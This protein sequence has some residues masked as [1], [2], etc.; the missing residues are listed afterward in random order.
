LD[1]IAPCT[2]ITVPIDIVHWLPYQVRKVLHLM[3]L[4]HLQLA[5]RRG[6]NLRWETFDA[7]LPYRC[8]QKLKWLGAA[9]LIGIRCIVKSA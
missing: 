9:I 6:S 7:F 5:G 1:G 2:T 3:M 4:K 8:E